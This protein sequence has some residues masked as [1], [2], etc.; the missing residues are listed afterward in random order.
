MNRKAIEKT[1]LNKILSLV[2]EYAVLD[3]SRERL[4]SLSPETDLSAA[5]KSLELTEECV[6][7]LF[8]Y[9]VGK[10][11]YFPPFADELER[12]AKGS[13]LSC[14]ELLSACSLLRAARIAHSGIAGVT[15]EELKAVR[16][17]ADRLYFDAAL[18]EDI[19][20]K[21][22]SDTEVSD[23]AS[24]RLYTI[25]REIRSLN[26]RIRSRLAEYLT[27][28][29]GKY[30]QD[31]IVTMRDNRYVL[32]VR[33]EY[34]RN[35]KGFIHDR[36]ASGATFFIEPEQVLEMN[37]E[38]RSLAIDEKEEVERILG[39]LSRRVGFMGKELVSDI[40]VLEELDGFYARAE[41]A[42]K[43][44]SV[45]PSVNASGIV[46]FD[47]GRHPLIDRK[48]VVPITL[49]LGRDYRFLLISGPNTGGKTVTLK[50]VGLFCLMA[51][52]GL[53]I[54]A[55]R[56]EV[57]VFRE[58]YCDIG[59]SQ[60]I[61]E[62]LSTFSSHVTNI[63]EIV[64]NADKNSLVL[65][66]ELGGGTDPD[67]GQALAKAVVSYLLRAGGTGVVTTHYSALKEFAFATDGIENACMEFD[68]DTLRP[69]YVIKIGLPGSSN[70]LAISR[71]LGLKEEILEEA[72]GNLSEGAQT[73]ENIVRSA[74]ESRLRADEALKETNLLKSEWQEKVKLLEDEREKLQKERE[75]LFTSAKAEARRIINE[76][77]AEAEEI[78]SEIE[79][80]FARD[81]ISEA[82]LIKARTLK[83][84]LGDKAYDNEREEFSRPQYIPAKIEKLKAGD[85][86]FVKNINQEGVVQSVRPQKNEA[87][88]LCGNI[89][90]RSKISDLSVLISERNAQNDKKKPAGKRVSDRVQVSKNLTPK[91]LPS[92][93]LNVIGMTVQEALPE[94]E[95]FIDGAVCA[96]LEEVRI[97][98]G[99]GTGKL[100][101]GIQDYLK[102]HRNV[103]E[104]RLGKYGEGETGVTIV[105]IK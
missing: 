19:Q 60:S 41:Y 14:G 80:I 69:L 65:I 50:M 38:L 102:K 43:L 15:D 54:P 59:D 74:E 55:K 3:G 64:D 72:L 1:E 99:V 82:D 40:E 42:Y 49:S 73:F 12:A 36:S 27:G 95:A 57:S 104:F 46:S 33:A 81:S 48:K 91:P 17:L 8:T 101:A 105:K 89:R 26:E 86:V 98:H 76:R 77:T 18:E 62:S 92:L 35:I 94:V 97:V 79:E 2:A 84:R 83:N 75:K 21:I 85:K 63:V 53:F 30:L 9:G 52:C 37:N 90:V 34:K 100:R 29:E 47:C 96:N 70:A 39:E 6:K 23:Y 93:E 16:V 32:P 44:S 11:E 31:G 56:A 45:K 88:V 71:R 24:D 78:L 7:L 58:I 4:K 5:K 20:T 103:E 13:A 66:D 28:E 25:R 10:I 51:M 87:E 68:S 67:E 22:L 61:E